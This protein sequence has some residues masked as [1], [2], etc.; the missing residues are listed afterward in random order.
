MPETP[1]DNQKA[2]AEAVKATTNSRG[3]QI[4]NRDLTEHLEKLYAEL[5]KAVEIEK[6]KDLQGE[7][8]GI[9][10]LFIR[11]AFHKSI[12]N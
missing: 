8:R 6:I 4:L 9:E 11:V 1:A 7:I 3:W 10:K 2:D 5:V 12:E